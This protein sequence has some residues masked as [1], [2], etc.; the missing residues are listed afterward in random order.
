MTVIV[1]VVAMR[2]MGVVVWS[3]LR[4]LLLILGKVVLDMCMAGQTIFMLMDDHFPVDQVAMDVFF[5][6]GLNRLMI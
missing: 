5:F 4:L 3:W 2:A 6:L 1:V